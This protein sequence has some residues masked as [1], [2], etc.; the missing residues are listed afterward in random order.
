[1]NRFIG[2][3]LDSYFLGL[4]G[5]FWFIVL[6]I[7]VGY[8]HYKHSEQ[9]RKREIAD[10]LPNEEMNINLYKDDVYM[11]NALKRHFKKNDLSDNKFIKELIRKELGRY[12]SY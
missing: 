2:S 11:F 3:L 9:K 10:R 5:G 12:D 6:P 8:I 4:K 1:M 7:I